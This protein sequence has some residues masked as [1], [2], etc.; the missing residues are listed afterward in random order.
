MK[1][2][3]ERIVEIEILT[4]NP[5]LIYIFKRRDA[6]QTCILIRFPVMQR[7]HFVLVVADLAQVPDAV[8]RRVA[9]DM[10]ELFL[11]ETSVV[12]GPDNMVHA[13]KLHFATMP[14]T[15]TPIALLVTHLPLHRPA[16]LLVHELPFLVIV[17]V[18]PLDAG[19]QFRQLAFR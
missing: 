15:K 8:V 1:E 4:M 3:L 2:R 19:R 18:V 14:N 10:V 7:V 13:Q 6:R 9:V 17:T 5:C 12:P 11:W 16:C